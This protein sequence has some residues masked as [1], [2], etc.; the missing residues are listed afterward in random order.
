MIYLKL[1]LLNLWKYR[2]RTFVVLVG[3]L[4]SVLVM[5]FVGGML[6]GMRETFFSEILRGSGHVQLHARGWEDRLDRYSIDYLI[7]SPDAIVE[8]VRSRE[9]TTRVE[10]IL[11]FGAV[12]SNGTE[13]I[14]L[15]GRGVVPDTSYFTDAT[16]TVTAGAFL[17][18]GSRGI[19][20][21]TAN[22]RLLDVELGEEILV[23][24]ETT[25]GSPWYLSFPV[26]G[27]Y[28]SGHAELDQNAF[29]V[30]HADAEELLFA[31]GT[32]NEIRVSLADPEGAESFVSEID[33]LLAE[34]DL[35]AVTWREIHGSLIVFVEI[36][37]VLAAVISALVVIVAAS[38]ITNA[39]LMTAF[40]RV[41]TFGALRAIG[42]KRRQL[43]G[44]IVGE[45]TML[46]V[47]GSVAGLAV[48]IPIVLYLQRY[49]M[50]IG[51]MGDFFGTGQTYYFAFEPAASA[52]T[53]V[54]GVLIATLS[55]LYAGWAT[56]RLDLI[57][58]LQEG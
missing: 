44:M 30:S 41:P 16:E 15:E 56:A 9:R 2:K 28:E 42:M 19:A 33:A 39:I 8:A 47:L 54:Y 23:L 25:L 34:H 43:L 40:D 11:T 58:S 5:E 48:G 14:A 49:G 52:R 22:A 31:E 4:L 37:D 10:K 53:F 50:D 57:G 36:S 55:A 27:L 38:V 32:T 20:L 17:P 12:L 1:A 35:S 13:T 7:E 26:T 46:G 3:I 45:G 24:V 21:S 18:A 29:F 6:N 51:A